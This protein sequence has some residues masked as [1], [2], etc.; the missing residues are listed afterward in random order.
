MK[1]GL[2]SFAFAL[3]G[4]ITF[5]QTIHKGSLFG[6]HIL[7]PNL[8][9]GVTMQDYINFCRNR[10]IPETEKAFP[11]VKSYLVKSI[12]GEDSSSVGIIV[13]FNSESDRNKY[14][15]TTGTMTEAGQAAIKKL[16]DA[17]GKDSEKYEIP[18]NP[19]KYNDWLVQ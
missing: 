7:T 9:E 3:L 12:R 19:D 4:I 17:L 2:F 18:S 15:T 5:G 10:W 13:M 6:L 14:W 8:K 1:K 16:G 11:G